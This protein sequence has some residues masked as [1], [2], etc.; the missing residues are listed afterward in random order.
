MPVFRQGSSNIGAVS[1]LGSPSIAYNPV[2][3]TVSEPYRFPPDFPTLTW[4]QSKVL[5]QPWVR[6]PEI[7]GAPFSPG[8]IPDQ[9]IWLEGDDITGVTSGDPVVNP[10][11]DMSPANNDATVGAGSGA[12]WEDNAM[13]GHAVVRFGGIIDKFTTPLDVPSV[14]AL[15][16]V[17]N[18]YV[19]AGPVGTD[20][21]TGS[22]PGIL[23]RENIVWPDTVTA[24]INLSSGLAGKNLLELHFDYTNDTYEVFLDGVSVGTSTTAMGEPGNTL[25]IGHGHVVDWFEGDVAA[26][27]GYSSEPDGANTTALRNYLTDKYVTVSTNLVIQNAVHAHA[28][29]NLVL[30]QVHSL[31]IASALHGHSVQNLA[32][33]MIHN[34]AIANA[35]HGH[36]AQSLAL[37]QIH[38][39]A[40]QAAVHGHTAQAL[41][42]TQIHSLIIANA[43]HGHTAANVALAQL[44]L[45][46][47]QS[48]L[49][50]HAAQNVVLNVSESLAIQNVAHGHTVQS[51][52]LSQV[53]QLVVAN[54][55]H[56]HTAQ[57]PLL[58][59]VHTLAIQ[60][61]LHGHTAQ[62][63]VLSQVHALLIQN[64]LHGHTAENVSLLGVLIDLL[65]EW[66]DPTVSL[67]VIGEAELRYAI[68]E[69]ELRERF[70]EGMLR[71]WFGDP[72]INREA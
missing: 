49:H 58:A 23:I 35:A 38:Q 33:S 21:G 68:G 47:I 31:A 61:A 32:L 26:V 40:I 18:N 66:G 1:F 52:V 10:W 62:A 8:D 64:V 28:A 63:L 70:G 54:A 22:T 44:H 71:T 24:Q 41:A 14:V 51:L 30:A 45:L 17:Y 67:F 37:T 27:I 60:A 56:G 20:G 39:L 9:V 72:V 48:G 57:S 13:K 69:G 7:A 3:G 42:L 53:H 29:Q 5:I 43:T 6:Q 12:T 11:P 46:V 65:F 19:G 25:D 16:I 34:L 59:Q 36:M 50:G 55:L 4:R 15:F 2:S